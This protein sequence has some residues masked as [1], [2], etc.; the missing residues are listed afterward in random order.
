MFL[1]INEFSKTHTYQLI[2]GPVRLTDIFPQSLGEIIVPWV[3]VHKELAKVNSTSFEDTQSLARKLC[4]LLKSPAYP[5][6]IILFRE[7]GGAINNFKWSTRTEL[8]FYG[9]M[10]GNLPKDFPSRIVEPLWDEGMRTKSDTS[11]GAIVTI[12]ER[13]SRIDIKELETGIILNP[14]LAAL[15][16]ASLSDNFSYSEKA[17]EDAAPDMTGACVL[18]FV[19]GL[20]AKDKVKPKIKFRPIQSVHSSFNETRQNLEI[21]ISI[22][23]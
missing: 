12:L 6:L 4:Q 16:R 8:I 13:L 2:P 5:T 10:Q 9:L 7:S 19:A 21:E 3:P 15:Q 22:S 20:M 23:R 17:M 14:L 11:A 1:E 18:L